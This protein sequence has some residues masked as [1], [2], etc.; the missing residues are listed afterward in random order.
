MEQITMEKSE[1]L[2]VKQGEVFKTL[3]DVENLV[4]SLEA[5]HHPLKVYKSESVE[6]YNKKVQWLMYFV[7]HVVLN[8]QTPVKKFL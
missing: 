4:K 5:Q 2:T 1:K 7:L 3:L 8:I 6:S